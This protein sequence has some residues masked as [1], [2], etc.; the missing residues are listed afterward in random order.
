M[1][2]LHHLKMPRLFLA[3]ST[4]AM[5]S[6]A[7]ADCFD[8][9]AA[10]HNVNPTILRAIA[11]V[12][13]GD[14][15]W[16]INRN[17]NGSVDYGEMQINSIHLSELAQ[18]GVNKQDLFDGCKSIYTGAWILRKSID[19]YGNTW[20]AI[21]TYHSATPAYRDSYAAKVRA[22][23]ERLERMAMGAGAR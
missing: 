13:S 4:L 3:V 20:S 17:A 22:I 10:F 12:E 14:K 16:A 23:A 8:D 6:T 7:Y 18:Y 19:R 11:I 2:I 21:G 15:P 1:R 5:A 9:A